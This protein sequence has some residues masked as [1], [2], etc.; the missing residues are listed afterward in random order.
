MPISLP[1]TGSKGTIGVLKQP[2]PLNENWLQHSRMPMK[3]IDEFRSAQTPT[4]G[5]LSAETQPWMTE[6]QLDP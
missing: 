6:K 1:S 5:V 2:G 4:G 3:E